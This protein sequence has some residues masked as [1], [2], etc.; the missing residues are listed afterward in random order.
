VFRQSRNSQGECTK[1]SQCGSLRF[2]R[3]IWPRPLLP[4]PAQVPIS[5]PSLGITSQIRHATRV[6]K[7]APST[8]SLRV[9]RGG[10]SRGPFRFPSQSSAVVPSSDSVVSCPGFSQDFRPSCDCVPIPFSKLALRARFL[11]TRQESASPEIFLSFQSI[12]SSLS[13]RARKSG[14]WTSTPLTHAKIS[15]DFLGPPCR[16]SR[17]LLPYP[18]VRLPLGFNQFLGST[19]VS[20]TPLHQRLALPTTAISICES[21]PGKSPSGDADCC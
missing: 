3:F 11:E 12:I 19:Y 14:L 4:S 2:K 21:P 8:S 6:W 15:R 1:F 5:R 10:E 16:N 7:A 18:R 17:S 20:Q 13:H 9:T